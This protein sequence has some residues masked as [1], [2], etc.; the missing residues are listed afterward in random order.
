M[1]LNARP[2]ILALGLSATL[3]GCGPGALVPSVAEPPS[4]PGSSAD[5]RAKASLGAALAALR[6]QS[7]VAVELDQRHQPAEAL[8]AVARARD[9]LQTIEDLGGDNAQPEFVRLGRAI[10]DAADRLQ[11]PNR[12][13]TL[14]E[15]LART[16]RATL[17]I[18]SEFVGDTSASPAYRASVVSHLV[19]GAAAY[20]E[21]A[22]LLDPIDPEGYREAYGSLREAQ[23]IYEGLAGVVEE[24][25]NDSARA[26]D[27]LL[28]AMFSAMPSS[29]A[30]LDLSPPDEVAAAAYMLG[31][32]LAD[33]HG[34]ISLP[35]RDRL[36]YIAPLLE[37]ALGAYESGE[38]GVADVLVQEVRATL[39]CPLTSSGDSL[40]AELGRLSAAIRSGAGD[41]DIAAFVEESSA[42]A[43]DA[44]ESR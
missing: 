10:H 39:C 37:E 29:E 42:L 11:R 41:S 2:A 35:P 24:Q 5:F 8:L 33:D 18:E 19:Y 30:P 40:E 23:N 44:A 21:A 3:L 16:G 1:P 13:G 34:A 43:A 20:Y 17:D 27:I 32:L 15:A 25:I 22:V 9:Y 31:V 14:D 7:L 36:A 12:D 28:A 38:A 4:S 6:G 26:A